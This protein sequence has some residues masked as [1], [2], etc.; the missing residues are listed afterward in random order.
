MDVILGVLAIAGA[1]AVLL[2]GMRAGAR[3]LGRGL[4]RFLVRGVADV[5]ARRGDLTGLSDA[6]A[7]KRR[8]RRAQLGAVSSLAFWV[9][10]GVAPL[11]TPWPRGLYAGYALFWVLPRTLGRGGAR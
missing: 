11:L 6:A 9:A 2:R 1:G 7:Q 4:E 5:R 8:A 3:V 10:L